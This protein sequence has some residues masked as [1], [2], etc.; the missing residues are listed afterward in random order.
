[1]TTPSVFADRKFEGHPETPVAFRC[2]NCGR[3][4]TADH[5]GESAV[6]FACRNCGAGVT[7]NPRTKALAQELADPNLPTERRV[8]IANE[9]TRLAQTGD[10]DKLL[11]PDNWE[12][13]A[14]ATPERL[15]E[16][17]IHQNRVTKHTG[18]PV[19][20]GVV[21]GQHTRAEASEAAVV[22]DEAN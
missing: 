15:G 3:L 5:A 1:M 21:S 12:V 19:R 6:P 9:L 17:G 20:A 16:L 13:L 4:E 14:D 22:T 18:R 11:H 2:R 10:N 8:A 7:L